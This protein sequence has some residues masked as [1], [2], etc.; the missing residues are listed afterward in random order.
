MEACL[1]ASTPSLASNIRRVLGGFHS[2]KKQRGVDEL[3]LRLYEPL[4]FRALQVGSLLEDP[5]QEILGR[6]DYPS[7][8]DSY[9]N[10]LTRSMT[11]RSSW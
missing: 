9:L 5:A 11:C 8:G 3:L 6:L 7:S 1:Y 10:V 2:Q 4:L